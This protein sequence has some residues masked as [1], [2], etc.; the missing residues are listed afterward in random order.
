MSPRGVRMS[1]TTRVLLGLSIQ[2]LILFLTI[3]G[4]VYNVLGIRDW[5]GNG[6]S[7]A[8]IEQVQ[9]HSTPSPTPHAHHRN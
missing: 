7:R 8:V 1:K 9:Q 5:F 6:V 2:G 3:G 4:L